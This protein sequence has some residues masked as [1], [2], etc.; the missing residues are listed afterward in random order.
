MYQGRYAQFYM[1]YFV[2]SARQIH[3]YLKKHSNPV[4]DN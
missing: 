4:T 2:M 1:P 3:M